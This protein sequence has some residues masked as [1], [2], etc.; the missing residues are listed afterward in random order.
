MKLKYLLDDL[1]FALILLVFWMVVSP[2]LMLVVVYLVGMG[3]ICGLLKITGLKKNAWAYYRAQVRTIMPVKIARYLETSS[4]AEIQEAWNKHYRHPTEQ[5]FDNNEGL[6]IYAQV[7]RIV[8]GLPEE[9]PNGAFILRNYRIYPKNRNFITGGYLSVFN[10]RS[11]RKE[12]EHYK[13]AV[14]SIHWRV[15]QGPFQSRTWKK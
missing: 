9:G 7:V 1:K 13:F 11:L 4:M 5:P 3:V 12:L 8:E 2:I 14:E 10:L 15:G 6:Q